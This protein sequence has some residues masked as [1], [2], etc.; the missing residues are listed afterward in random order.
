MKKLNESQAIAQE[1]FQD[2]PRYF[3]FD[4]MNGVKLDLE[5]IIYSISKFDSN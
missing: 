3:L 1:L 4:I 2:T 5:K